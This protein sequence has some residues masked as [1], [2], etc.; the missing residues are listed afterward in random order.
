MLT[1]KDPK[2]REEESPKENPKNPLSLLDL[3]SPSS[4]L[5]G[6]VKLNQHPPTK[7]KVR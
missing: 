3:L 2:K 4:S 7:K 6:S 5:L 1:A